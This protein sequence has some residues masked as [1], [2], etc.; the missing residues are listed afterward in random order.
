MTDN[1][2]SLKTLAQMS[3]D[4]DTFFNTSLDSIVVLNDDGIICKV[5]RSFEE[6]IGY[7]S[8]EMVGKSLSGFIDAD[9]LQ[10][11]AKWM[12]TLSEGDHICDHQIRVRTKSGEFRWVSWRIAAKGKDHRVFAIGRDTTQAKDES[13]KLHGLMMRKQAQWDCVTQIAKDPTI[14]S[15]DLLA[16][17]KVITELASKVMETERTSVWMLEDDGKS[18]VCS[19]IFLLNAQQH[20]TDTTLKVSDY[21]RYFEAIHEGRFV[22]AD[23]AENDP[24]TREYKM[25][26]LGSRGIKSMLDAPVRVEGTV[27]GLVCFEHVGL[28]RTWLPDEMS[29]AG[30]I[31]DQVAQ[32]ILTSEL[33]AAQKQLRALNE[34]LE[35]RVRARTKE[36]EAKN[37][38]LETFAYSVSHDLRAPLR[39]IAG[40]NQMIKE[41]YENVLD[42]DAKMYIGRIEAAVKT[43]SQLIQDLLTYSRVERRPIQ[44]APVSLRD[45]IERVLA[46]LE[47]NGSD[48]PVTISTDIPDINLI[49]DRDGVAMALRNLI[50]NAVKFSKGKP[51]PKVSISAKVWGDCCELTVKDNGIGFEPKYSE[52]IFEIFQRLER[53]DEFP[54]TG[55]GL[56]IV[57]K[58]V[59]RI[60]GTAFCESEPGVGSTFHIRIPYKTLVAV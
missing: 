38:E 17:L 59:Q 18:L 10:L 50:D 46:E 28:L 4:L 26:Y 52:T 14:A 36:L 6:L 34:D 40:Y 11:V 35:L 29:F 31:A 5:N 7:S 13:D 60:G 53:G 8:S 39:S 27:R 3:S 12:E 24:Q 22:C 43:M 51:D 25:S 1:E 9:D 19:E 57:R 41:D 23:D 32:L 15:G 30:V 55:V 2:G 16:G 33:I 54:G 37:Q 44:E 20:G 58:A 21:P 48:S 56:A 47:L 49:T 42:D 45:L